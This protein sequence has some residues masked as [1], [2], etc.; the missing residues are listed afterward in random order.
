M[1]MLLGSGINNR[2]GCCQKMID[3]ISELMNTLEN[4]ENIQEVNLDNLPWPDLK[5]GIGLSLL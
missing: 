2:G 4:T 5:N 1:S 3:S